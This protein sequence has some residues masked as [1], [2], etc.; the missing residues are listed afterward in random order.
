[1]V[2]FFVQCN[3][4]VFL[5]TIR[6]IMV[7][8]FY[9]KSPVCKPLDINPIDNAGALSQQ[10]I[11]V[12]S[13]VVRQ[14]ISGLKGKSALKSRQGKC[15]PKQTLKK[16]ADYADYADKHRASMLRGLHTHHPW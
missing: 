12:R 8:L 9:R 6:L 7:L 15:N 4:A 1:M 16:T 3:H 11:K 10:E 2:K 13:E 5:I 14:G